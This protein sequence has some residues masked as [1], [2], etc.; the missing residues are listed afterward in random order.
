LDETKELI[1]VSPQWRTADFCGVRPVGFAASI[2]GAA[3]G[4][5]PVGT[6]A[7]PS[8]GGGVT[9]VGASARDDESPVNFGA[10]AVRGALAQP[11]ANANEARR[12]EEERR[13]SFK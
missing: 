12:M 2:G 4:F 3:A 11:N 8:V 9:S 13:P 6:N 7:K 5:A 1:G 10:A